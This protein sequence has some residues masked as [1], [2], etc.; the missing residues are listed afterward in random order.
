M[1]ISD[2]TNKAT[3]TKLGNQLKSNALT[4]SVNGVD[5]PIKDGNVYN[6]QV[7][8]ASLFNEANKKIKVLDYY[9]PSKVIIDTFHDLGK[10]VDKSLQSAFLLQT[11]NIKGT[12]ILCAVF[13]FLISTMSCSARNSL[14]ETIRDI[15]NGIS[16]L[17]TGAR[18]LNNTIETFNATADAAETIVSSIDQIFSNIQE[19][20]D[21]A[22]MNV[23]E[24]ISTILAAP[25]SIYENVQSV[26]DALNFSKNFKFT[27]PDFTG[28]G[29]W[30]LAQNVLFAL[31]GM[32]LQAA[33]EVLNKIFGPVE[34]LIN[35]LV[36]QECFNNMADRI[37]I[38]ILQTI[39]SLKSKIKQEISDIFAA[40][41]GFN[42]KFRQI[43]KNLGWSLELAALTE[44][45]K[46]VS[47]NFMQIARGCGVEPCTGNASAPKYT[48]LMSAGNLLD[49]KD[50][51]NPFGY[52][53]SSLPSYTIKSDAATY[54]DIDDIAEKFKDF[55][56][57]DN[58]V[59]DENTIKSSYNILNNA[60][61]QIKEFI[62]NGI[63]N[64]ILDENYNINPNTAT[65]T[66]QFDK[67]CN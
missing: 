47:G 65:I 1:Q 16:I 61:D 12:D 34:D 4:I 66:Y 2:F 59:I 52:T 39:S 28:I 27:M 46:Y 41:N 11:F 45:L 33:D 31:Q 51:I 50:S 36:P 5:I 13:C 48:S 58:I 67:K 64:N 10:E 9:A 38:S 43:N 20:S 24:A 44:A 14:Y 21:G 29:I 25:I 19:T 3:F 54:E 32:L 63:L 62:N 15:N 49:S 37:R 18:A 8:S 7:N 17:N 57:P 42:L 22:Q 55:A 30:D 6:S 35:N 23:P 60:P 40:N 53:L 56:S 26:L